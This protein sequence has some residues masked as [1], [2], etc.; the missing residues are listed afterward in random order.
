MQ[1]NNNKTLGS[2]R[3]S[4]SEDGLTVDF[5]IAFFC[6]LGQDVLNWLN[7]FYELCGCLS[8]NEEVYPLC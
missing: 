2:L 3:K 7:E 1:G 8:R 6:I 4:A 5:D